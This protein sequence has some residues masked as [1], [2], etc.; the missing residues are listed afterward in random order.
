MYFSFSS[1]N[2]DHRNISSPENVNHNNGM[3]TFSWA[4]RYSEVPI[5][6]IVAKFHLLK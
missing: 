1:S 3:I 6:I 4:E 2:I 5:N